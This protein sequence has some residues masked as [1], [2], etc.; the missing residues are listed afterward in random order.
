[1]SAKRT[2]VAGLPAR[3]SC[4]NTATPNT[5]AITIPAVSPNSFQPA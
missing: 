5:S 4:T 3:R 2:T 1:M